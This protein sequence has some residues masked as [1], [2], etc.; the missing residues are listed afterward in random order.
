MGKIDE[1]K[2]K[3]END[4]NKVKNFFQK[5]NSSNY[6]NNNIQKPE[7]PAKKEIKISQKYKI[8]NNDSQKIKVVNNNAKKNEPINFLKANK[9][10]IKNIKIIDEQIK[11]D[12]HPFNEHLNFQNMYKDDKTIN[13]GLN[14]LINDYMDE[15]FDLNKINED[16]YNQI[17]YLNN[18]SHIVKDEKQK[19]DKEETDISQSINKIKE[20]IQIENEYLNFDDIN[21]NIKNSN[22]KNNNINKNDEDEEYKEIEELKKNVIKDIGKDIFIMV[23]NHVDNATDKNEI[24]FNMELLSQQLSKEYENKKYNK[25]KLNLALD[26]LPEIF[27]IVIQDRLIKLSK[28]NS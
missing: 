26:K 4:K 28:N 16:Q 13:E 2:E 23:Y 14:D 15:N 9:M 11:K 7:I 20:S 25:N 5:R 8:V 6:N 19:T 12:E 21:L 1:N 27:A 10:N 24:K 18:L 22:V 17:R 3:Y